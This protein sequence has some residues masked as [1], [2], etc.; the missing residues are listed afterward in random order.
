MQFVVGRWVTRCKAYN[1]AGGS[2]DARF[3]GP[4]RAFGLAQVMAAESRP[5]WVIYC[6]VIVGARTPLRVSTHVLEARRKGLP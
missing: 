5:S 2:V 1:A 4:R 6:S 3:R